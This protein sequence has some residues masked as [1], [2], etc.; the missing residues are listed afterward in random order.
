MT[1][2]FLLPM[3]KCD[4]HL[5]FTIFM[6]HCNSYQLQ[7]LLNIMHMVQTP[8]NQ[9]ELCFLFHKLSQEVLVCDIILYT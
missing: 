4:L 7:I 5:M 2:P 9:E 8:K 1:L 3:T 6:E